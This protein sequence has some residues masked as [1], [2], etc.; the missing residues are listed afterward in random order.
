MVLRNLTQDDADSIGYDFEFVVPA[1]LS[2]Q[3]VLEGDDVDIVA[4]RV[5][6]NFFFEFL[7][8]FEQVI[9]RLLIG[10]GAT[11]GGPIC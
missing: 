8:R 5:G 10:S 1:V 11:S 4:G 3:L 6:L 9:E 7:D 2:G